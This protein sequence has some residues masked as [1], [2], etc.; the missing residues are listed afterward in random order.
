MSQMAAGTLAEQLPRIARL[1]FDHGWLILSPTFLNLG[2]PVL[3]VDHALTGHGGSLGLEPFG[4][5]DPSTP[6]PNARA[7]VE[8]AGR[9]LGL[10]D[11][12]PRIPELITIG[13]I[14][15]PED[16]EVLFWADQLVLLVGDTGA[17][18]R[19]WSELWQFTI[20]LAPIA[21]LHY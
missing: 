11:T 15:H 17:A 9:C 14:A 6:L 12:R 8:I 2:V 3:L 10:W 4:T 1:G 20:G 5:R 21:R 19:A 7:R 13:T 18:E 16:L